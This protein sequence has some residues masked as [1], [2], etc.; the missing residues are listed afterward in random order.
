MFT[1]CLQDG[2][3]TSSKLP[4]STCLSSTLPTMQTLNISTE[5]PLGLLWESGE[6]RS[7]TKMTCN[8]A[9]EEKEKW[10]QE[11]KKQVIY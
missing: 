5:L 2:Y 9:K 7:V 1:G 10:M 8:Q 11:P 4:D 6:T 3:V